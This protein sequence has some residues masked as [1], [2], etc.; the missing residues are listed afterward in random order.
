M[1][2]FKNELRREFEIAYA[3]NFLHSMGVLCE[4]KD[5]REFYGDYPKLPVFAPIWTGKDNAASKIGEYVKFY[6]KCL[7]LERFNLVECISIEG[8]S[9]REF[10]NVYACYAWTQNKI[11]KM[12][13]CKSADVS[14]NLEEFDEK[15][16]TLENRVCDGGITL[17]TKFGIQ[18]GYEELLPHYTDCDAIPEG[19]IVWQDD[20]VKLYVSSGELVEEK[21]AL[22]PVPETVGNYA[23]SPRVAILGGAVQRRA[24]PLSQF[25][26]EHM[27]SL[28]ALYAWNKHL[29]TDGD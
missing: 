7:K 21:T 11:E 2:T 26:Q 20:E 10:A 8:L 27:T 9:P 22:N 24:M 12:R 6:A 28:F 15:R 25:T 13:G 19:G 18:I 23:D 5:L 4:A 3:V 16:E 14:D 1:E 29:A 17:F